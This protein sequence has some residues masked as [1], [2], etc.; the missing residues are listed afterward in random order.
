MAPTVDAANQMKS[1][2]VDTCEMRSKLSRPE[3]RM[4]APWQHSNG[5]SSRSNRSQGTSFCAALA[6]AAFA[7][8]DEG[9]RFSEAR[10]DA[11]ECMCVCVYDRKSNSVD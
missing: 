6:A 2:N 1:A 9:R 10:R 11:C 5:N 3:I 4:A 8:V 7:G